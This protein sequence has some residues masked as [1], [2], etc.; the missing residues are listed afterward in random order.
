MLW[1]ENNTVTWEPVPRI[2]ISGCGQHI[3]SIQSSYLWAHFTHH[4][5]CINNWHWF[6]NNYSYTKIYYNALQT[7]N[8]A[9]DIRFSLHLLIFSFFP[10]SCHGPFSAFCALVFSF[11]IDNVEYANTFVADMFFKIETR[12]EIM[13][14]HWLAISEWMQMFSF[15]SNN[16]RDFIVL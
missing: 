2:L 13:P 14:W 6:I 15:D 3:Y 12:V 7:Q 4:F 16:I 9:F 10:C 1:R 5:K 8:R 11:R